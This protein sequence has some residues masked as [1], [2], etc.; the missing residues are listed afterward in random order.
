MTYTLPAA[1]GSSTY[2]LSTNGSGTLSWQ[3]PISGANQ[4][5]SNLSSVSINA[6]LIPGSTLDVGSDAAEWVNVWTRY[7]KHNDAGSPN[8]EITVTGNSG[9]IIL[10]PDTG[11]LL[12]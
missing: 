10:Q 3:S 2:V 6:S 12:S 1:D 7:L 8:L 4:A 5:L 9:S 11:G